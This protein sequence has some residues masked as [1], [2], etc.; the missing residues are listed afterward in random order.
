MPFH[1]T[2]NIRDR[3]AM[4]LTYD[5]QVTWLAFC[6][7]GGWEMEDEMKNLTMFILMVVAG[8]MF[9]C[10]NDTSQTAATTATTTYYLSNGT[11]YAS[12][13]GTVASTYCGVTAATTTYY[14]SNGL[15]YSSTTGTTVATTYCSSTS[16]TGY[17]S[18]NGYCYAYATGQIVNSTYCS[19]TSTTG[20]TCVGYYY[21][22]GN[23]Y[24][25]LVYCSGTNCR[26]YTM[27]TQA[28]QAVSCQ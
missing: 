7:L 8:S 15:C 19:T 20:S 25:Q 22:L 28:G 23:G 16:S 12:T 13:G 3:G 26:G 14:W 21:Y 9:G 10:S 4:S 17:Y 6:S 18:V 2:S 5:T 24:P 11:C 27:Y 1:A